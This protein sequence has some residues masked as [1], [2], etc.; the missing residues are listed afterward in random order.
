F[1]VRPFLTLGGTLLP[2]SSVVICVTGTVKG[3]GTNNV[4]GTATNSL[5]SLYTL[6]RDLSSLTVEYAGSSSQS[7]DATTYK[8]LTINN[9]AGV[10]LVNNVTVN[11]VLNLA[12]GFA[13]GLANV[14]VTN[15]APSAV[16]ATSGWFG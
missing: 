10:S 16:K 4:T 13:N 1:S 5:S 8:N 3:S 14:N 15:S 7:A 9:A 6:P 12:S 2:A 11:G